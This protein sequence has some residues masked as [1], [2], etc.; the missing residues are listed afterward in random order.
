[1]ALLC[2]LADTDACNGAL[3]LMPGSHH[4]A[5]P[6]HRVLPEPHAADADALPGGHPALANAAEQVTMT[7]NAGDAVILDYRLLHGTHANATA[8]R[9]D[10]IIMS[11]APAWSDLPD[12]LRAQLICHPALPDPAEEQARA[13]CAYGDLLPRFGGRRQSLSINRVPPIDFYVREA[14]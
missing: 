9:R 14:R 7:L 5:T 3:R 13:A 11:F 8:N 4:A 10:A 6:L 2:Y 1:V 12:D